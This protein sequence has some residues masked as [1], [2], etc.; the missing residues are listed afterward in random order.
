MSVPRYNN[1]KDSGVEWL[2]KV[3]SGWGVKRIRHLFEIRKR[4]SGAEGHEVLSITQQGIK[5]KD[6]ESGDGQLSADYSKSLLSG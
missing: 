5:P 4:I 6:I 3:P 2:G 1:Y